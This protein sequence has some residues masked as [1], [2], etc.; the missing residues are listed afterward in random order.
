MKYLDLTKPIV[1]YD[2][3]P[4]PIS[5]PQIV[6]RHDNPLATIE[7]VASAESATTLQAALESCGL[8]VKHDSSPLTLKLVLLVYLRRAFE[9]VCERGESL[10]E[11]E[12]ALLHEIA[13][14]IAGNSSVTLGETEYD[15]LVKLTDSGKVKGHNNIVLPLYQNEVRMEVRRLVR[16][17]PEKN[18]D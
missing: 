2:V 1:G 11:S 10:S 7:A 14:R 4:L 16:A 9:I 8:R 13:L 6:D 15:T 18:S 3:S 17:A 12:Q 5:A